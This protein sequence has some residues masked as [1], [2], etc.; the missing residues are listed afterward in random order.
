VVDYDLKL[1]GKKMLISQK[2]AKDKK[3]LKPCDHDKIS[4]YDLRRKI[5]RAVKVLVED[6]VFLNNSLL[7]EIVKA[8]T[9]PK[10]ND[11]FQEKIIKHQ[12]YA[13]APFDITFIESTVGAFLIESREKGIWICT[14]ISNTGL[15]LPIRL[16][17]TPDGKGEMGIEADGY[18]ASSH[19]QLANIRI[20]LEAYYLCTVELLM[21]LNTSNITMHDYTPTEVENKDINKTILPFYTYKV[22]D[23]FRE[24]EKFNNLNE[25][26]DF[27]FKDKNDKIQR[28]SHL[29]KGHFKETKN[30]LFWW[31]SFTRC[32]KNLGTKGF[33]DKDYRLTIT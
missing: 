19:E 14:H 16:K 4:C 3:F 1:K 17:H 33:V 23:I 32:R 8:A 2:I 15:I 24:K 25:V 20:H 6:S 21:Y 22:L 18:R 5:S 26:V 7:D 12:F 30:G 28:R 11:K 27:L 10:N 29:V 9:D 13:K 31:N